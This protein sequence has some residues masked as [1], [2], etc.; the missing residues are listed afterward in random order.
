MTDAADEVRLTQIVIAPFTTASG[1]S[2]STL[3]LGT[4]GI[5]YR[6]D[7]ECDGWIAWSMKKAG[8]RMKHKAKR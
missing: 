4:D 8:C 3:G 6:F 1:S 5:V 7:P 2:Y